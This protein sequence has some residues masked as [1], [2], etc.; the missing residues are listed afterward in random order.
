MSLPIFFA[1]LTFLAALVPVFGTP[2][3]WFP[4][5]IYL[6]C[7]QQY[8]K[9]AALFFL[10]AFGISLIDNFLKPVLIGKKTR[11]PYLLLF[12]GILGGLQVYGLVG[13][14]LAPAVLSFFFSLI[15]IY[16]EKFL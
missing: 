3:V 10:G 2:L 15:K 14:F 9:A 8:G 13:I 16:R 12:L 4:F 7:L 6:I 5:V 1:A 11:L